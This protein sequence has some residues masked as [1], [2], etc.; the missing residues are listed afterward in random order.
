MIAREARATEQRFVVARGHGKFT[1]AGG[2]SPFQ[3]FTLRKKVSAESL[4]ISPRSGKKITW[5]YAEDNSM[6][7]KM[8]PLLSQLTFLSDY[9]VPP[10]GDDKK[11]RN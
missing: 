2:A 10:W 1:N 3:N 4:A 6:I 8:F 9:C 7:D 11:L 5:S